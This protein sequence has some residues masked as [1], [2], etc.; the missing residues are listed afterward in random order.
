[1]SERGSEDD[2]GEEHPGKAAEELE[3]DVAHR[4]DGF[5]L[6]EDGERERNGGV[7]VRAGEAA[8]RGGD[9]Q[10]RGGAHGQA[11]EGA[12]DERVRDAARHGGCGVLQDRH[13]RARGEH[14]ESEEGGLDQVEVEVGHG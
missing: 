4:V 7:H 1:V 6:A 5:D 3:D 10:N 9:E 8:P 12:A 11:D 13:P 2:A 14:E